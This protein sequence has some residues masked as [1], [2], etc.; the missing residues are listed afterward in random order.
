MTVLFMDPKVG[1]S[2]CQNTQPEY[3]RLDLKKVNSRNRNLQF[4]SFMRSKLK[5]RLT[6][7]RSISTKNVFLSMA[8]FI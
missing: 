3:N 5:F 6:C 7:L 2:V 8:L 1:R 4:I